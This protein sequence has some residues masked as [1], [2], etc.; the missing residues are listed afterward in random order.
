MKSFVTIGACAAALFLS[1]CG[2]GSG[3]SA[4]KNL[5]P[6]SDPDAVAEALTVKVNGVEA[7]QKDGEIPLATTTGSEP[8]I[9]DLFDKISAQNGQ[10][11][12]LQTTVSST[13]PLSLLFSKVSG[14]NS[15]LEFNIAT[16][17]KADGALEIEITIPQNITD[18]EFCQLYSAQDD[19]DRVSQPIQICFEI[20]ST[21]DDQ[22]QS[23]AVF[24]TQ[25]LAGGTFTVNPA[26]DDPLN[27][28]IFNTDGSGSVRFAPNPDNEFDDNDVNDISWFVDAQGRLNIT[29]FGEESIYDWLVTAIE[30]SGNTARFSYSVSERG[31]DSFNGLTATMERVGSTAPTPTAAATPTPTMTPANPT[32]M[33][34][35]SPANPTPSPTPVVSATSAKSCFNPQLFTPGTSYSTT[36]LETENFDG[37]TFTETKTDNYTV[38]GN[39]VFDG[40]NALQVD[41]NEV[42]ETATY[43]S[44]EYFQVN[45]SQPAWTYIGYTE[46]DGSYQ[47]LET[48]NPGITFRFDLEPGDTYPYSFSISYQ[49]T[50][51][52]VTTT[53][54]SSETGNITYVGRAAVTVPAGT[55]ETCRYTVDYAVTDEAGTYSSSEEI[56][57]IVGTGIDARY[58]DNYQDQFGNST[59]IAELLSANINGTPVR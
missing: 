8:V 48:L 37:Q 24:T 54:N 45:A 56:D 43:N 55:F 26:S 1:A 23:G 40:R 57:L 52:G 2:G 50:F 39:T 17:T 9:A 10:K 21:A 13:S 4:N 28:L 22:A 14:A 46:T 15:F 32:P 29:E 6:I 18:G 11:I 41:D 12:V 19:S 16:V 35:S 25:F 3:G 47:A 5:I 31:G 53:Y 27:Q 30:I 20:E 51:D 42:N 7:E 38:V 49:E 58:V 59:T 36:F 33:P 44:T 34:S